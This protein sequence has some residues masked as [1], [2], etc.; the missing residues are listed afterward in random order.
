MSSTKQV[1]HILTIHLPFSQELLHISDINHSN[2]IMGVLRGPDNNDVSPKLIGTS[3][4]R[5]LVP[6]YEYGHII[7]VFKLNELLWWG[8]NSD[9]NRVLRIIADKIDDASPH[10]KSHVGG[11]FD[12]I[13]M[14]IAAHIQDVELD[15]QLGDITGDKYIKQSK[16]VM[17]KYKNDI[18]FF[19][20]MIEIFEEGDDE[21]DITTLLTKLRLFLRDAI[22]EQGIKEDQATIHTTTTVYENSV[23]SHARWILDIA[24]NNKLVRHDKRI[25]DVNREMDYLLAKFVKTLITQES[26]VFNQGMSLEA[27]INVNDHEYKF[28]EDL[29]R[30]TKR[31]KQLHGISE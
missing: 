23:D 25:K 8:E 12:Q 6:G 14:R 4:I 20:F 3:V 16:E 2:V 29:K 24:S 5:S 13:R 18:R 28:V 21:D 9:D 22:S 19:N 1:K 15:L 26:V 7:P 17:D 27:F 30:I 11:A 31:S 10:Y